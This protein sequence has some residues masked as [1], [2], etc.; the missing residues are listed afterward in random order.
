MKCLKAALLLAA[1]AAVWGGLAAGSAGATVLCTTNANCTTSHAPGKGGQMYDSGDTISA[2]GAANLQITTSAGDLTCKTSELRY[3]LI[4]T[5]GAGLV[6]PQETTIQLK[7]CTFKPLVGAAINCANI[8][9]EGYVGNFTLGTAPNGTVTTQE[10]FVPI[11]CLGGLECVLG[12][13]DFVLPVTGGNPATLTATK[14]KLERKE[15]G[16]MCPETAEL[17]ATFKTTTPVYVY[18]G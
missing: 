6:V 3:K 9:F 11:L 12:A 5:G 17:D 10:F 14:L 16:P 1:V 15:G 18:S 2:P 7:D 8:H 4:G 13:K